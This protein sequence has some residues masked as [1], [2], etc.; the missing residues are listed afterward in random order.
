M[1]DKAD[2]IG[3]EQS[4]AHLV[5]IPRFGFARFWNRPANTHPAV[6]IPGGVEALSDALAREEILL[7]RVRTM[8]EEHETLRDESDH[9]LLNG[10]QMVISLLMLQSRTAAPEAS[11]QLAAAA[12]RVMSIE[13]IHRRLHINDGTKFVA[14]KNYLEAFCRDISGMMTSE[15][16]S[17]Q[18]ILVACDD[19]SLPTTTAIPLGFIIS[20]LITNAIKYGKGSVHVC[21][22]G[23][24]KDIC[25]LSVSTDGPPLPEGYDPAASKGLGMKI[26]QSFAR[27]VGGELR[28]GRGD[29]G[30]GARFTV[31][32]AAGMMSG[33]GSLKS[34]QNDSK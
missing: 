33:R 30:Q 24:P 25:A 29:D 5:S 12:R 3:T 9:R 13:R 20:E 34:V 16:L 2:G 10:L 21:L 28:I 14:F 1:G 15:K 19:I 4:V 22:E 6:H 7:R 23:R 18:E 8:A 27:Q 17:E 26:I 31:L 32:F 11:G